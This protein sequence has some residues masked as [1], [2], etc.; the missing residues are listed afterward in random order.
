MGLWAP[1]PLAECAHTGTVRRLVG[2]QGGRGGGSRMPDWW[3]ASGQGRLTLKDANFLAC[4]LVFL[5]SW[6]LVGGGGSPVS[7]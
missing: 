7:T 5:A 3:A 1:F 6:M 2:G 4:Q